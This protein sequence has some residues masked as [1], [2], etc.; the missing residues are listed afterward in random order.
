MKEADAVRAVISTPAA[1]LGTER[2]FG[3][4]KEGAMADVAVIKGANESSYTPTDMF[5]NTVSSSNGYQ[6]VLTASNG[7]V[8]FRR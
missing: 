2:L 1:A 6:C 8:V 4:V 3:F 7:E 5:G